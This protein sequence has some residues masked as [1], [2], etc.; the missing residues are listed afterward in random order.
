MSFDQGIAETQARIAK[1]KSERDLWR[2]SGKKEKYFEAYFRVNALEQELDR[3][4]R[5]RLEST[6]GSER[7]AHPQDAAVTPPGPIPSPNPQASLF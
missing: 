3:L 5:Q 1:A 6:A 4:R 7:Y 2:T